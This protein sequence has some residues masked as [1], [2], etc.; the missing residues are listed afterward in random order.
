MLLDMLKASAPSRVVT[1]SSDAYK[2]AWSGMKFDDLTLKDFGRLEPYAQSK[3][4][5]ILFTQ[6][7]AERLAGR[8]HMHAYSLLQFLLEST[9]NTGVNTEHCLAH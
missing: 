5:N 8:P 3:L 6:E 2:Y 7:L 9:E 1:V 4:A